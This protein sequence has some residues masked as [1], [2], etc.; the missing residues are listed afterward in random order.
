MRNEIAC[1][2][3]NTGLR[4]GVLAVKGATECARIG[5]VARAGGSK[6]GADCVAARTGYE[7]CPA[8]VQYARALL[9]SQ[10]W[11][12]SADVYL[13]AIADYAGVAGREV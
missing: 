5:H 11:I 13:V 10:S 9:L 1:E 12:D 7:R 4:L 3:R 6:G 2:C 8:R